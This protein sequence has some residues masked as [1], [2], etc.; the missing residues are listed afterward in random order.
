MDEWNLSCVSGM[1]YAEFGSRVPKAGSVYMYTYVT[2][3]EF[4]AFMIGWNLIL[5]AVFGKFRTRYTK[6][7]INLLNVFDVIER[8]FRYRYR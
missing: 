3:G 8:F 5:E 1:C 7:F 6:T 2:I 4:L